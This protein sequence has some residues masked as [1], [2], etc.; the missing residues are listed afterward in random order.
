MLAVE[1]MRYGIFASIV[2]ARPRTPAPQDDSD[3]G[4]NGGGEP[5]KAAADKP[6]G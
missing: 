1:R 5:E 6:T 4:Q 2:A 3:N